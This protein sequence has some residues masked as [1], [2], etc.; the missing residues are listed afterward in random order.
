MMPSLKSNIVAMRNHRLLLVFF[1]L[2]GTRTDTLFR[3]NGG[4]FPDICEENTIRGV[5]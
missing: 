2:Q 3:I 1:L 5:Q 4:T